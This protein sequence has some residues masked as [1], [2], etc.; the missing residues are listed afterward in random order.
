[1]DL[2]S[3]SLA[4]ALI[5]S[6]IAC[7][8]G[9]VLS[10]VAMP[11]VFEMQDYGRADRFARNAILLTNPILAGVAFAA[12]VAAVFGGAVAM[13]VIFGC[14]GLGFL[15]ARLPV[16]S[17]KD[18]TGQVYVRRQKKVSRVAAM[19]LSAALIPVM[20]TGIVLGVIGI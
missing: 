1:M 9:A 7:G 18:A 10:L 5:L 19:T 14:V 16:Q 4:I 15:L 20:M 13:A 11:L 8:G 6:G 17:R 12:A 2:Q 3:L